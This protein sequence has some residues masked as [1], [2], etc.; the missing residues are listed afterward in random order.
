MTTPSFYVG[1][2]GEQD[3]LA[4]MPETWPVPKEVAGVRIPDSALA[5]EATDYV[6]SISPPIVFNHA[7][8]TYVFGEL[9]A[10]IRNQKP[11]SELFFLG[12]ILHDLGQTAGYI[13]KERFEVEGANGA[14]TWLRSRSVDESRIDV[15]WDAI[16]LH[17]S[18]GIVEY[19]R[20]EVSLVSTGAV[21]DLMGWE[22]AGL[23]GEQALAV[24]EAIPRGNFTREY[25]IVM[26][27]QSRRR[28][29]E[30]TFGNFYAEMG[31]RFVPGFKALSVCDLMDTCSW[32]AL[33]A[34]PAHSH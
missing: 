21:I 13:G 11:D 23:D 14:A 18:V 29:V 1:G 32:A 5:R 16:A 19:K 26:G 24:A 33:D 27:E 15:V 4:C 17:T 25:Q 30:T 9:V 22:G 28:P 10:R 7:L 2:A 3:I 31:E 20:P 6:R 8:R 12:S 34:E